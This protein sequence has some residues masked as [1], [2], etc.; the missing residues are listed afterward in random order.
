MKSAII[1]LKQNKRNAQKLFL[2]LSL[3]SL[4]FFSSCRTANQA[5][6]SE[7]IGEKE[8]QQQQQQPDRT[9]ASF[10]VPPPESINLSNPLQISTREEDIALCEKINQTIEQSEHV[11][12]RWGV[13]VLSLK[14]GRIFCQ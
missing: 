7:N 4:V 10:P 2:F 13:F 3:L 11:N 9:T 12:A 6:G 8:E 5:K 14:D 1:N